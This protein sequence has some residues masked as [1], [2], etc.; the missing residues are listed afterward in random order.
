[1]KAA[2]LTALLLSMVLAVAMSN[3]SIVAAEDEQRELYLKSYNPD[4]TVNCAKWCGPTE[5]CC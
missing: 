5:L 1:M 4:G 3:P 2:T